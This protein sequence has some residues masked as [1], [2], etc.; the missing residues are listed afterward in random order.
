MS[1]TYIHES[2][3]QATECSS[4]LRS[5]WSLR[6]L[7]RSDRCRSRSPCDG[8]TEGRGGGNIPASGPRGV[9][10]ALSWNERCSRG[11]RERRYTRL[12]RGAG[13]VWLDQ[14]LERNIYRCVERNLRCESVVREDAIEMC[15]RR[16]HRS[17]RGDLHLDRGWI[18][19]TR[20]CRPRRAVGQ[21]GDVGSYVRQI[22]RASRGSAQRSARP[23]HTTRSGQS[24]AHLTDMRIPPCVMEG[25]P[26]VYLGCHRGILVA[27]QKMGFLAS[28]PPATRPSNKEQAQCATSPSTA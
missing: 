25:N 11:C 15:C 16:S 13:Q 23:P 24:S 2:P 7:D 27:P 21:Q 28:Q 26:S 19:D 17:V 5:N 18:Y 10:R 4:S 1:N 22:E 12:R 14:S 9:G 8:A 20:L 3:P 6:S